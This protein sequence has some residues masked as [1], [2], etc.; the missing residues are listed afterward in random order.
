MGALLVNESVKLFKRKSSWLMPL[1]LVLLMGTIAFLAL[2]SNENIREYRATIPAEEKVPFNGGVLAYRLKDGSLVSQDA[3]WSVAKEGGSEDDYQEIS[4]TVA[5]T[6]PFLEKEISRLQK[7]P[8]ENYGRYQMSERKQELAYYQ[9]YLAAGQTPPDRENGRS[10]ANFFSNFGELTILPTIMAV[11][12]ASMIIASEFSGG[13]IKLL[14]TRPYSRTQILLSKYVVTVI[15]G[16]GLS[17]VMG[18]SAFLFSWLLPHQSILLP[19]A[20]STGAKTGLDVAVSL[21]ASNFL[22]LWFYVTVAF[23][24][25][26]VIRSQALAVGVGLG[27]L[28]SGSIL[29]QILPSLIERHN[30]LKWVIFNLLSLNS[31]VIYGAEA[32]AGQMSVLG[33]VVGLCAYTLVVLIATIVLFNKRDVAL[34]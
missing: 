22:L 10:S 34:S 30:W 17:L 8:K 25:S 6:V 23:F 5:E 28:L 14:L 3:F 15:Y 16:F 11:I 21:F 20:T 7:L 4:L 31:R 9:A 26:A 1:F 32:V 12:V 24:C 13:T 18:L 27:M 29:G 2:K 33:M 19:L